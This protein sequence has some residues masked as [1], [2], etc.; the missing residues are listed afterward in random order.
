MTLGSN[1]L[2]GYTNI[3]NRNLFLP[4]NVNCTVT[5]TKGLT[6]DVPTTQIFG[7]NSTLFVDA[8]VTGA[9]GLTFN[10]TGGSQPYTALRNDANSFAESI[11]GDGAHFTSRRSPTKTNP[12]PS[13]LAL[14]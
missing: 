12:P 2:P 5:L 11:S 1:Y 8:K 13:A 14:H 3:Y 4:S 7:G 6:L 10:Y 9:D